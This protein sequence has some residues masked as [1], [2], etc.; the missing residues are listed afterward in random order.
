MFYQISPSFIVGYT[1]IIH[2]VN[3]DK[4]LF[5]ITSQTKVHKINL[6]NVSVRWENI[7]TVT[8][9]LYNLPYEFFFRKKNEIDNFK[10]IYKESMVHDYN[11]YRYEFI[12]L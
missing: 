11:L 1:S 8:I 12:L 3:L 7:P 5:G 2:L 9:F 10:T 6:T 4:F